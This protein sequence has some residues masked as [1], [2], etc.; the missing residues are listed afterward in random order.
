[1]FFVIWLRVRDAYILQSYCLWVTSCYILCTEPAVQVAYSEYGTPTIAGG[2]SEESSSLD[3]FLLTQVA[4]LPDAK[5]VL[6]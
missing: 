4:W 6:S 2:R 1:M 5:E 3:L